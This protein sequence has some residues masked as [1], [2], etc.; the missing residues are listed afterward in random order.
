MKYS[1]TL[2]HTYILVHLPHTYILVHVYAYSKIIHTHIYIRPVC[3]CL[4][5]YVC[6]YKYTTYQMMFTVYY[7]LLLQRRCLGCVF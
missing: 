3:A 4:F 1:I 7:Y 5:M 2:P 6:M